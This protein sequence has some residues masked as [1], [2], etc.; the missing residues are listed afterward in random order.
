MRNRRNKYSYGRNR[1]SYGRRR[2]FGSVRWDRLIPV[3]A[4]IVHCISVQLLALTARDEGL[5]ME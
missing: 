2:R 4:G 3:I 5:L 1:Y